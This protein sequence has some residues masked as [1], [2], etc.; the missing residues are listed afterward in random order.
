MRKN[1][2]V[3]VGSPRINGNT[4]MICDAFIEG[5]KQ[6]GNQ[7]TKIHLGKLKINGCTG[8]NYYLSHNGQC[9]IRDDIDI[10]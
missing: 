7:V 3:L 9:S 10:G 5:A 4:D 1:I 2:L 6:N 8:C